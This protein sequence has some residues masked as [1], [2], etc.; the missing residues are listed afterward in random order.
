MTPAQNNPVGGISAAHFEVRSAE[1]KRLQE[2]V[3]AALERKL[4]GRT[5]VV[6]NLDLDF[7]EM[8]KRLYTPGSEQDDGQVAAAIQSIKESYNN[9][10][11]DD[12]SKDMESEKK[13][14]NYK[15]REASIAYLS[16]LARIERIHATVFADGLSADEAA[17]LEK[18][19][20]HALGVQKERGDSVYVDTD[21]WDHT[22]LTT[23]SNPAVPVGLPARESETT[24]SS[25]LAWGLLLGQTTLL[26]AGLAGY[27]H[28]SRRQNPG[29]TVLGP[30]FAGELTTS[31]IVDHGRHKT[32][33][34]T[35]AFEQTGVRTTELL[36]GIV[37]ER[38]K[39]AAD[40]LRS[41]WLAN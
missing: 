41:T 14:V 4:P 13:S 19:V 40:L 29:D 30:T 12:S 31:G 10:G 21:A 36:E 22:L 37:R 25:N 8:E 33:E 11:G 38:P 5:E 20:A 7:S 39:Q 16:K 26:L 27:H 3:Q 32:G 17:N 28:L 2:K 6:V 18:S 9:Q 1:E 15:V 24:S 35:L 34:T 23:T